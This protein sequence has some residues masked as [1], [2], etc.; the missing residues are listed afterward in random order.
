MVYK[1]IQ[2][3]QSLECNH[4]IYVFPVLKPASFLAGTFFVA[5]SVIV[6]DD[7]PAEQTGFF[8]AVSRLL[9]AAVVVV[10]PA[11]SEQARR[12]GAVSGL[13]SAVVVVICRIAEQTV[14]IGGVPGFMPMVVVAAGRRAKQ[15][16][17]RR[18]VALPRTVFPV[19]VVTH[20]SCSLSGPSMEAAQML[21][22]RRLV[23]IGDILPQSPTLLFPLDCIE[24]TAKAEGTGAPAG[25]IIEK[26]AAR[27]VGRS[28]N[29][30]RLAV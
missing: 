1:P 28:Q 16:R 22:P 8:F 21:F 24:H 3:N 17:G 23:F 4:F 27:K 5:V 26:S 18:A 29:R 13:L 9:P 12:V 6:V 10:D 11:A 19:C 25:A 14:V 7:R 2:Y 30:Y 15:A 20:H